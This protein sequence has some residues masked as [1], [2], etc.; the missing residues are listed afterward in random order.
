MRETSGTNT[1]KVRH[2]KFELLFLV[3]ATLCF[4]ILKR[5]NAVAGQL[6]SMKK[7]RRE[8]FIYS[9]LLKIIVNCAE[10]MEVA[11]L[12]GNQSRN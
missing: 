1:A 2:H 11:V 10:Q 12:E 5:P 3:M 6:K 9:H 8:N 7:M 4:Q